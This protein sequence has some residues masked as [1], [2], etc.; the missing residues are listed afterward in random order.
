M[1]FILSQL[2]LALFNV[3]NAYLDAYRILK[4]KEIAH[5][6]NFIA[7]AIFSIIIVYVVKYDIGDIILFCCCAFFNR[8]LSFDIPL[9]LRRKL[10]WHYQSTA[11]PPKALWDKIEKKL[12][13]IDYDGKKIV[14]W[15]SLFLF[16]LMFIK[17][18]SP[19]WK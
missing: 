3:V 7:Y 4:H 14:L 6:I 2:A 11:N 19:L 5:A 13:G 15:Y 17:S 18:V 8:Q 12:F 9:N 1:T 10:P 16:S